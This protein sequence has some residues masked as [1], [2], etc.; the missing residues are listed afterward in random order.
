M[1]ITGNPPKINNR[2]RIMGNVWAPPG[3]VNRHLC[4][5]GVMDLS[6]LPLSVGDRDMSLGRPSGTRV[7][8]KFGVG[9]AG[10]SD[11]RR[12]PR[13]MVDLYSTALRFDAASDWMFPTDGADN[14]AW[15]AQSGVA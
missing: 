7:H 2:Q 13:L 10:A 8:E 3:Q 14:L 6:G 9:T 12:A 4:Q 15:H 5:F 11:Y 1:N